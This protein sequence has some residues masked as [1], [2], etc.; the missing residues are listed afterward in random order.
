MDD[1]N[2]LKGKKILIVDDEPDILDTLEGLLTE[3]E[4]E[5]ASTFEEAWDRLGNQFYDLAILDIMGV[6]GYRLLSLANE[7]KV[8]AVMLTAH[9]MT[10][11]NVVKS[12]KEGAA[13]F[14]PKE[15][16]ANIKS[17]L[18]DI[19]AAKEGGNSTWQ[20]WF[21]RL[22]T[23]FANKFGPD[24]QSNDKDFWEKYTYF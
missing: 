10:P 9:A 17:H 14:L 18:D 3:C 6:Q 24:W 4:I 15:E 16:M 2:R 7:R 19:L 21:S 11:D 5:K 8:P 12:Y 13:Y 22:G 23:F 20:N 1:E